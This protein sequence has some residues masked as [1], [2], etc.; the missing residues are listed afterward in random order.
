M[1]SPGEE[2]NR[3]IITVLG[4]DQIGIIA[5]V[6]GRLAEYHVNIL[7]ISQTIVKDFFTMIMVVDLEPATLELIELARTLDQE[8]ND[9]GLQ[10]KV[11]HEDIF[12]FMHRI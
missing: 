1:A 8:G 12:T 7:D 3:A 10:V 9:K 4:R 5:W 2:S 11:Q 6:A